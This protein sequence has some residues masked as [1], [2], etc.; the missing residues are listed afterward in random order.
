MKALVLFGSPRRG[1]TYKLTE[2]FKKGLE[3]RNIQVEFIDVTKLNISHCKSCDFCLKNKGCIF[4]DDMEQIYTKIYESDIIVL[5]SPVYFGTVTSYLKVLIDRCQP[6][7]NRRFVL[8]IEDKVKRKGVLIF[9]AGRKNKKM[10]DA[11]ELVA[12]Y[13][14][15]SCN[16]DLNEVIY[17]L[18]TDENDIEGAILET[19]YERALRV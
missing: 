4:K 18:N 3:E 17:C 7:Y 11:M 13:F 16:A 8:N 2:S 10:V 1:N 5:A 15:F 19:A 14:L 12:K 9:T 6:L